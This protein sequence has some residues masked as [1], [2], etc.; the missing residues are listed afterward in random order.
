[1]SHLAD[2][3]EF[4]GITVDALAWCISSSL[5]IPIAA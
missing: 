5:Q 3:R 2:A 1:L 4:R